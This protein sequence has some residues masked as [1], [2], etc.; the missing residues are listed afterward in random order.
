VR[1]QRVLS[2]VIFERALTRKGFSSITL[3]LRVL[4]VALI[5]WLLLEYV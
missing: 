3:K 5:A 1:V 2:Y 4:S